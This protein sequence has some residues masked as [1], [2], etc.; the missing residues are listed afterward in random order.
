M[1]GNLLHRQ[2][3][4]RR[5]DGVGGAL[6]AL[7]LIT[8]FFVVP[9]VALLLRSVTEPVPGLQNYAILFGDGTY[10][11]VFFNTFLVATVVTAVTVIVAFPVAWMLAIMPPALG[12]I[13]FGIII[14]SMW[15][16]LLTRT[17]AWMV[18]LQRT[19]VINR[20]LMDIGLIS[21]PLPLINNLTGV[22][23]GMVYI[24]LP[25]MILPL[26]GTLRAIDPMTLRAAALCG[27]SP[28]NAFR[29]I[30]LPLSLPGIAA[31]GL[32][33]FVMSLGYFVTPTLLGGTSNMMLAAMIAQMIQSLLNWGL[34]SAAA[35]ILLLV[36]MALYALQLRLVGAKRMTGGI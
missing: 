4:L 9:V 8:L 34:G 19:G 24:M 21:E 12:S 36:T 14:L 26:V 23:I 31:G 7:T 17:Y 22:T 1:S 2:P 20:T 16:N 13:V 35:F 3:I 28:F 29:R 6:P 25:F 33:V 15:T 30:L 5:P 18:L 27:A 10:A 11:R 32:M